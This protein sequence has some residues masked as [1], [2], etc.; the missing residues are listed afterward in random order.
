MATS[1]QEM[2][3]LG[4]RASANASPETE[5]EQQRRGV[6]KRLRESLSKSR[7]ALTE[8]ISASLFERIDEETWERLEEALI[9]ADA[10]APTTATVVERLEHEVDSGNG[11]SP[12]AARRGG[13]VQSLPQGAS[14]RRGPLYPRGGPAGGR[15]GGGHRNRQ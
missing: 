13:A 10:G 8:E 5:P 6:F 9:L 3:N 4:S 11:P 1:W 15:G 7:Q 12:G 14:S 2:I